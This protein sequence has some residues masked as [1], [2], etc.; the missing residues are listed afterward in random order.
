MLKLCRIL[1]MVLVTGDRG[2]GRTTQWSPQWTTRSGSIAGVAA[3][4]TFAR[5]GFVSALGVALRLAAST[6]LAH[7]R[8]V[9]TFLRDPPGATRSFFRDL[10]PAQAT[11]YIAGLILERA[12]PAA[13]GGLVGRGGRRLIRAADDLVDEAVPSL[14]IPDT[15]FGKKIGKH[16][17]D[18]GL[19]PSD[20]AARTLLRDRIEQIHGQA[21][22]IRQGPW[23]PSGSGG[24][25]HLFVRQG[26]DVVMTRPDGT[27]VTI[28]LGG[29]GN[30][31]F[32]S[33][34]VVRPGS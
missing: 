22:E 31:W 21:E 24:A 20:P 33:A 34:T 32:R 25:A 12:P 13:V 17:Q 16:A 19:D 9:A 26:E 6:V 14:R 28:L 23:N 15:Q 29:A 3:L 18:Y 1:D 2:C 27:F 5:M 8:G 10:T 11:G 30:G 7:G 4:L